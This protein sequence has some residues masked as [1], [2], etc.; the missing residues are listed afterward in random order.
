VDRL[1]NVWPEA[2]RHLFGRVARLWSRSDALAAGNWVASYW[3]EEVKRNLLSEIAVSTAKI[4]GFDGL[5]IAN[6]IEDDAARLHA[7]NQAIYWWGVTCGGI[8]L[9]PGEARPVRD[10]SN[11]F[12]DDWTD[13]NIRTFAFAT[14]VN[15]SKNLPDLLKIAKDDDQ[16][17]LIYEGA[18]RGSAWSVP[19]AVAGAAE[20][21]PDGFANTEQGKDTLKA[22]IR[23]WSEMDANGA[24]SWLSKQPPGAKTDALRAGLNGEG[25]K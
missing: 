1:A 11:G 9:V 5:T 21:L 15:Y 19:A 3:D 2:D 8:S 14:M 6:Q 24:R 20:Q 10:I 4:R 7:R 25:A 16:R 13:E 18:V 17:I 12:P 23:R 22:F